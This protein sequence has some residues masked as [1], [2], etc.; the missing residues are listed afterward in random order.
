MSH[1]GLAV[2]LAEMIDDAGASVT[3][4]V[5]AEPVRWLF[6]EPVGRV[7]V[8]TTDPQ[9][10]RERFSDVAP[11]ETLGTT[12]EIGRLEFELDDETLSYT[13]E[14]IAKLR[15]VIAAALE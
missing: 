7:V 1:G 9:E 8:E 4:P 2:T 6:S 11:V 10:V 5:D 15:D 3:L 12:T 14:E 13:R